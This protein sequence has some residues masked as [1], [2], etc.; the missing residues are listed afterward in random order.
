MNTISSAWGPSLADENKAI[1]R[2]IEAAVAVAAAK[3]AASTNVAGVPARFRAAAA[4]ARQSVQSAQAA[5]D[6]ADRAVR[7]R[8]GRDRPS[9]ALARV[10]YEDATLTPSRTLEAAQA[11]LEA[12]ELALGMQVQARQQ[13]AA[14]EASAPT[15]RARAQQQ[16]ETTL[17]QI[18]QR[19]L[20]ARAKCAVD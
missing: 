16:Y 11:A 12:A 9:D 7:A 5:L 6:Q 8:I 15:D 10:W 1:K 17:A 4:Q 2:D 18:E 19:L 20:A 13:L 3:N 14:L